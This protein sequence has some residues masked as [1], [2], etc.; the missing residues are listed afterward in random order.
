[1]RIGEIRELEKRI[2]EAL[3]ATANAK[4]HRNNGLNKFSFYS[5][6]FETLN[7]SDKLVRTFIVECICT[8]YM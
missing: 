5:H 6:Q 2:R 8:L 7:R 3:C 1:M 4:H